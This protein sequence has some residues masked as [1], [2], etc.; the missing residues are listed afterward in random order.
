M[1]IWNQIQARY[2]RSASQIGEAYL[3]VKGQAAIPSARFPIEF[4]FVVY[5]V[6]CC[7]G[8][9]IIDVSLVVVG[10]DVSSFWRYYTTGPHA[11]EGRKRTP[12]RT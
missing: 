7:F 10:R 1:P 9:V 4:P 2:S 3:L 6:D 5:V 12:S 8:A 11:K